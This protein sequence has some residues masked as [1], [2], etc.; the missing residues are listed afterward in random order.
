MQLL[1]DRRK[2]NATSRSMHQFC[3]Y[4][5]NMFPSAEVADEVIEI[6]TIYLYVKVCRE[7]FG[8]RFADRAGSA[9]GEW[10]AGGGGHNLAT[11]ADECADAR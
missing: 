10:L 3:G 9:G 11:D 8:R 4:V 6:A 5:R 7:V 1:L 2:V